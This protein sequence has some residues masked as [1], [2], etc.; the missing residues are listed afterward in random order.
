[1]RRLTDALAVRPSGMRG[2]VHPDRVVVERRIGYRNS[3]QPRLVG[4]MRDWET[5]TC[6]DVSVGMHP[7]VWIF[8][9]FW[10]LMLGPLA[11]SIDAQAVVEVLRHGTTDAGVI[12]LSITGMLLFA[13]VLALVGQ[14]LARSERAELLAFLRTVALAEERPA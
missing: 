3:F 10:V 5:G 6:F 2:R 12:G 4:R 13:V 1:M 14:W 9:A 8:L 11:L 7:A